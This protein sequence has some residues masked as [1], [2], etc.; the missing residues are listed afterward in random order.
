MKKI[1]L[2]LI[3]ALSLSIC[4]NLSAQVLNES[5]N[6][7][8]VDWLLTGTYS[9]AAGAV[10]GDPT[11]DANF[12]FDDD[13]AGA[14]SDDNIAAESPEIDLTAA[15]GAGETWLTV[16]TDYVFRKLSVEEFLR[17]QYFDADT[18]LWVNWEPDSMP[19]NDTV[20]TDDYC[21]GTPVSYTTGVLNIA[22]FSVLQQ[23]NFRYRI[24]YDDDP[25][26]QAYEYGFCMQSPTITSEVPPSCPDPMS[27]AA[28]P[29]NTTDVNLEWV[30]NG[31]AAIWNIEIVDVT[32]GGAQ[33]MTPTYSGVSNPYMET[34]LIPGNDY[35]FY[36]QSD[37]AG[38]GTSG[39]S[40]PA[41]WSQPNLGDVCESAIVV[42]ALPYNVSDDTAIYGDD[43][44]GAPGADCGPAND[45]LAGDDVVYEYTATSDTSINISLTTIGSTYTG[46]FAYNNCSDIGTLCATEGASNLGATDDLE[47]DLT[48]TN[49]ETYYIV[50]STWAAPQSTTYTLDIT[51]N[52]CT[53]ATVA[54][55]VVDDCANS[56]GF[57]ILV[58]ITDVGT[59][60]SIDINDDQ[61]S[62]TQSTGVAG[63]FTFGPY[64]NGTDIVMSI[65]DNDDANC[66][67]L[68]GALTQNAC[69]ALN[70]ECAD[71]I[72]LDP[73]ANADGSCTEVYSGSNIG[74]TNSA[75]EIVP[76]G[77]CA[78]GDAAPNDVWFTLTV[79]VT[80]Q[81]DF[82]FI[83]NP[84]FSTIVELYTGTCGALVA[85][86]PVLCN[87]GATR[88][89]AGLTPSETVYLRVWDYGSDEEG[90]LEICI[91]YL[92]C[93]PAAV[94][95]S[96]VSDCD[97]AQYQIDVDVADLGDA[98]FINDGTN[99][100]PIVV[101]S[102]V[103]GP[104]PSGTDV[105][106]TIEH[107][108][109]NCEFTIPV[110]NFACP[111]LPTVD[112]TLTI[113]GCSDSD[114][115]N[116]P[117]DASVKGVYWVQLDYD[118]GCFEITSDTDGSDFDTELGL[119]DSDGFLVVSNDDDFGGIT[120]QSLFTEVALPAGTYYLAAGAYN[121]AFGADNFDAT[122]ANTAD[123]GTLFVN[124]STPSDNTVDFC[125]LQFPF[126]GNIELAQ[127]FDVFTQVYEAG[128]T[129]PA[130]QGAGIVGW[131]GY[132]ETDATTAADFT[133]GD[134]TWV[135]ADYN[136]GGPAT[137]NDEYFAEIGSA[138]PV[139]TYYY[140]SRYSID[141][142]PFAYGGI[143]PGGSDGNFWDGT[144]FVSGVL[145]V[146]L[147]PPPVNNDCSGAIALTPGTVFEDNAL[148][149]QTQAGSTDS[150][151]TP[152]PSCSAFDPADPTGF[153]GDVWFS[154]V[155]PADGMI[156]IET[157]GDPAGNGG[158]TGMSVYSGTCGALFE[159]A[160][161]DDLSA[162]GNYSLVS[163]NDPAL[164]NQTLYVR[165]FEFGGNA[166]LNFQV[167]AYNATLSVESFDNEN[168]FT[169]FP[170]PVKNELTLKAKNNAIQNI[171]VINMLGQEVLKTTPNTLESNLDMNSLNQGSYFV[172]VTINGITETIRIIKQ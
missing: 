147:P 25:N 122:T 56:G 50:I 52:S 62:A 45:Y 85:L 169:Y 5:A 68:S 79:P 104:Y 73:F 137:N 47:F 39:W 166:L 160:C 51:E 15:F 157:Q 67:Q 82:E 58:D 10:E 21:A 150:G 27:L 135:L 151:E 75:G 12:A 126:E 143:N 38:S 54:Y 40:G 167:S 107:S 171:S 42:T 69:P 84:G 133:S 146:T 125:N 128:V 60:T 81:F 3:F 140:V 111:T 134:W 74:A 162:D 18:S 14:A 98:T 102:N 66:N 92:N 109:M 96:I 152:L 103:V 123:V 164:A 132:S 16:T 124:A 26:G 8:S 141:G 48:V 127:D 100:Y 149:G 4:S 59:S 95:T 154:V 33:T 142:G 93:A 36:V 156:D 28:T 138:R 90:V 57:N 170:N 80:G 159:E 46:V 1:T 63:M 114:S 153:G 83:T 88:T 86:D 101:G 112:A 70:D 76:S 72:D 89:F 106:L 115:Y 30:E 61:G 144:N 129:E 148:T 11:V 172:Q 13:D 49:G 19:G 34:M 71:A 97:N 2:G 113:N 22:G 24:L 7:P 44:N 17:V 53:D 20:L 77:A 41:A 43:Y 130:G 110:I 31:T 117:Y 87:N 165:V 161:D 118:G 29:M 6:W 145:N 119:Y 78:D 155:V 64:T 32:A 131:I 158:D 94:T 163:I 99:S 105:N 116:T 37:C 108:D 23:S 121:M 168:A 65:T 91:N 136:T 139:G 120:P 35:E 9:T 55:S